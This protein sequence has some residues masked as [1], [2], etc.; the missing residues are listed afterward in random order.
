[1]RQALVM[2]PAIAKAASEPLANIG[3]RLIAS[4]ALVS[5]PRGEVV[6]PSS[7]GTRQECVLM[8]CKVVL[9]RSLSV[10]SIGFG[11]AC[12]ADTGARGGEVG[13][14]VGPSVLRAALVAD[15]GDKDV[16][17]VAYR[18]VAASDDCTDP[19]LATGSADL[20]EQAFP[21]NLGPA[22]TGPLHAFAAELFVLPP[23]SYRVCATPLA[24]VLP[25]MD[26][27]PAEGLAMVLEAATSEVVLTSQCEGID[28]GALGAATILNDPPLI[29]DL[30]FDPSYFITTCETVEIEA[31]A[32]DPNGDSIT[33]AWSQ[34]SG[35][36]MGT[37]V[38][39]GFLASFTSA[40]VGDYQL[41][42]QVTDALGGV[43]SLTFPIHVTECNP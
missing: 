8:S 23:G 39:G 28:N 9:K 11:L 29:E 7:E 24:G 21:N 14:E 2:E 30:A 42:L 16:T 36:A 25:S 5:A 43:G 33:Y 34:V 15:L 27:G 32:T 19:P 3:G 17:G 38:Q 31:Q 26:C 41:R 4:C 18:I 37:L 20:L 10:L 6:S 1:V 22:G 13:G 40:T 35:P 12:T